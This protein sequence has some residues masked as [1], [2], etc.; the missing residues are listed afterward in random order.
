MGKA[1]SEHRDHHRLGAGCL[2]QINEALHLVVGRGHRSD[3][4]ETGAVSV[5]HERLPGVGADR[6]VQVG[7][8]APDHGLVGGLV[9]GGQERIQRPVPPVQLGVAR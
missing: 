9:S 6:P 4:E 8:A 7:V 1:V 3:E 2:A 5:R